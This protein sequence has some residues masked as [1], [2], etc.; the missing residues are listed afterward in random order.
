MDISNQWRANR[1]RHQPP[2][3]SFAT[4]QEGEDSGY[5]NGQAMG[6]HDYI[7]GCIER[8]ECTVIPRVPASSALKILPR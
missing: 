8:N 7:E 2:P 3:N 5:R 1:G 6:P 4:V